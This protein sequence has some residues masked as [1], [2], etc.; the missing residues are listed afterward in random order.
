MDLCKQIGDWIQDNIEV[1]LQKFFQD[2]YQSCVDASHWLETIEQ[3]VEQQC[4]EQECNWWCLCC[5]KWF[6]WLATIILSVLKWIADIVCKLIVYLI[7]IIITILVQILKWVVL[8]VVCLV[9]ALCSFL[10]LIAGI[11]L[12]GVLLSLVLLT[13]PPFAPVAVPILPI[14]ATV[15]VVAFALVKLLCEA[16]RCRLLGVIAWTLKWSITIGAIFS[17]VTLSALSAL[18]IALFGGTLAAL[19]TLMLRLNCRLPRMFSVP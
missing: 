13:A 10:F 18:V 1:P 2:L 4:R 8:A 17:I 6:C 9:A 12:I 5:N 15:F 19:I 3:R 16:S 11:A 7:V 14:A